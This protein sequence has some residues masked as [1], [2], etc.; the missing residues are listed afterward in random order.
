MTTTKHPAPR[1]LT[2]EKL[3]QASGGLRLNLTWIEFRT[4]PRK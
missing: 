1:E 3:R 2:P 4:L